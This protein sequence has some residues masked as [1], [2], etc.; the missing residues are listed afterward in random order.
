MAELNGN[1]HFG[2]NVLTQS[3][4]NK[5][6]KHSE[7]LQILKNF[8]KRESTITKSEILNLINAMEENN[9]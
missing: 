9:E 5:L 6:I 3:E 7:Q 2:I 1:M 8:I 4:Y